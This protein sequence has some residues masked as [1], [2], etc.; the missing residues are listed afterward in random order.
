MK[1]FIKQF[2]YSI[3]MLLCSMAAMAQVASPISWLGTNANTAINAEGVLYKSASNTQWNAGGFSEELLSVNEDGWVETQLTTTNKLWALGMSREKSSGSYAL[4]NIE[5][6][7]YFNA[8]GA[9]S[10][11]EF[12]NQIYNSP[13]GVFAN[14]GDRFTIRKTDGVVEFLKNG[15]VFATAT[16]PCNSDL[17]VDVSFYSP[18]AEVGHVNTSFGIPSI[19]PPISR[20]I[21]YWPLTNDFEDKSGNLHH[22]TNHNTTID[23]EGT[24][25]NGTDAY[26]EA[27]NMPA[28]TDG[29]TFS[30]WVKP[31]RHDVLEAYV[32]YYKEGNG[33]LMREHAD[34][35]YVY[36]QESWGYTSDALSDITPTPNTWQHFTAT[37]S[38][39]SGKINYYFNGQL[40]YTS[41]LDYNELLAT[42]GYAA[43]VKIG[44]IANNGSESSLIQYFQGHLKEVALYDFALTQAEVA[45]LY[46]EGIPN[47]TGGAGSGNG[48]WVS[49]N[50]VMYTGQSQVGIGVTD[51]DLSAHPN[52]QLLIN[53]QIGAKNLVIK[54]DGVW[55]DYVFEKGYEP[56]SLQEIREYIGTNK[57]LPG[58]PSAQE[59]AE[60]GISVNEMMHAQMQKIEEMTL[61]MIKLEKDYQKQLARQ[62]VKI[63]TLEKIIKNNPGSK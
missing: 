32:Q 22:L 11:R 48:D 7:I 9:Y 35:F 60:E 41:A 27:F 40:Y 58:V 59:I 39:N 42:I 63:E 17:V 57:H 26:L 10:V 2:S 49:S 45:T 34:V 23:A 1:N 18:G 6:L 62:Q 5:Y 38:A 52:Y 53:G 47:N 36:N 56:M 50:D 28:L 8:T 20:P 21:A 31:T 4:S 55:P 19:E 14:L 3:A 61:L 37:W 30:A 46:G 51:L 54:A 33:L 13:T 44:V 16:N 29:F 12:N 25:F 24:N 43:K 15:I